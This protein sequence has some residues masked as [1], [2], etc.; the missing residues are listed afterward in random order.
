MKHACGTRRSVST[1]LLGGVLLT[2]CSGADTESFATSS[3][4]QA[5]QAVE[6][7]ARRSLAVTEQPILG[8]FSLERVLTQLVLQSGVPGVT[9]VSLFQQWWDT[10]NPGPGLDAGPHCDDEV[11]ATLGTVL[12]GY[13]YFCRPAPSEGVQAS[14]DP[15]APG[16]PCEYKPIGLFNRFD[17]APENGAN[18]GEYRIIYGKVSGATDNRDRATLIFEA[19]M[20]NPLPYQGIKGCSKLVESWA[21][22]TQEDDLE[23]RADALE[24]FYF[25]GKGNSPPVVSVTHFGD[26]P[27]DWGQIRT[28]QFVDP[29]TGWSLREYKLRR[30]CSGSS[31]DTL[32]VVP[33]TAKTNAFGGLFDPASTLPL[34][35]DFRAYFPTQVAS[36]AASDLSG[37]TLSVPDDYN[38][39]QSQASGATAIEMK[40]LEQLTVDPSALRSAIEGELTALGS[41][42]TVEDIALRAQA[43]TCA[44][45]HRLND[46]VAIGGGLVWP[47]SLRFVHVSDRETEEVDGVTRTLLSPALLD[48]FLPHRKTVVEDF[49]NDKPKVPRGPNVPIGGGMTHG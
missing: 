43:N 34:A 19:V 15:F 37:I 20:P 6:I 2:A 8:R 13:P 1:A 12:N 21:D 38:T 33:V 26:N 24:A 42:L 29:E 30:T 41:S 18:C 31:C 25:E 11:D 7:D 32:R 46:D 28:N 47:A 10:Q 45:C 3:K 39:G 36:L 40:Y 9:P 23:A 17:L 35:A 27:D 5:V 44:G 4:S 16:S 48:V 49:L 14:C 22:L